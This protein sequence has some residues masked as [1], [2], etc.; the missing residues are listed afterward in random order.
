[1]KEKTAANTGVTE[2]WASVITCKIDNKLWSDGI[3]GRILPM[4]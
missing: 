1:M 2:H 4:N 3:L